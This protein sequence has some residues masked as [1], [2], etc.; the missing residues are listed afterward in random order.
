M[1]GGIYGS[2][3]DENLQNKS[4]RGF[5]RGRKIRCLVLFRRII[6]RLESQRKSAV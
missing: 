4:V 2:R 3:G 6:Q 5:E 1:V